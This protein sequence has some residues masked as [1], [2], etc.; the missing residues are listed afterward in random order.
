MNPVCDKSECE[1]QMRIT[2]YSLFFL[3][4]MVILNLLLASERAKRRAAHYAEFVRQL[5]EIE[6]D[7][8]VHMEQDTK[9]A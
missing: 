5:K 4:I 1:R 8:M 6:D 9:I 2:A 3:W 7:Q